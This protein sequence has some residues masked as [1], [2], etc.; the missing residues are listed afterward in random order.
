MHDSRQ[1]FELELDDLKKRNGRGTLAPKCSLHREPDAEQHR[2]ARAKLLA[3]E[4]VD[5]ITC[6]S[7]KTKI[8]KGGDI[9]ALA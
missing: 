2:E 8:P 3:F 6:G 5:S 1:L 9:G 7:R 4:A